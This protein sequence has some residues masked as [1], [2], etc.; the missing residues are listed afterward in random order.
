MM[1]L[2]ALHLF[3]H[4][5][6]EYQSVILLKFPTKDVLFFLAEKKRM[7]NKFLVVCVLNNY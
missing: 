5:V 2:S 3:I 6:K 7:K 4:I 1:S